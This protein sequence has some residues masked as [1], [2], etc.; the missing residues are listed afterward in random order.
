[1]SAQKEVPKRLEPTGEV[2]RELFLKSGNLC[3]FPGCK[4]FMM[5]EEGPLGGFLGWGKTTSKPRLARCDAQPRQPRATTA[6]SAPGSGGSV[7]GGANVWGELK[8]S[9]MGRSRLCP[10]LTLGS[11]DVSE[12]FTAPS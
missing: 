7:P 3:A 11:I 8:N 5:N 4:S 12:S 2:L 1:M 10:R 9:E 6:P